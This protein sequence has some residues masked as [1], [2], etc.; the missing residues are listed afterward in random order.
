MKYPFVILFRYN[1][2]N[3][4]DDFV[5]KYKDALNCSISIINDPLQLNK[6]YD[7]NNQILM[8][9][10]KRGEYI[11][12]L[13]DFL[14]QRIINNKWLHFDNIYD[15][16]TMDETSINGFINIIDRMVNDLYIQN[17][18]GSRDSTR[19]VFS[20]FTTCYNSYHKIFRAYTSFLTQKFI[21]W[22]W[23]VLD[24]SPD[25]KHFEFL[26]ENFSNDKRVRLYKRSENSGSIGN[27]KN[28]VVM[29]CRGKYVLE[30]DHDDEIL[31]DT[32]KDA[33]DA[34]E[35]DKDVGFV[36][37]DFCNLYE[38]GK[39]H[40][41]GDFFGLGYAGYHC[42]KFRNKWVYVENTPNINNI[43]ISHLVSLPNHPRIW[44][45]DVLMKLGNYSEE[46][47]ICDDQ[48]ILLRT[49]METKCVKIS[50]LA[51]VQYMNEGDNNFSLIRN[52]EINRIGPHILTPLFY[53]KYGVHEKM[54]EIGAYEDEK[55]MDFGFLKEVWLRG[56]SYEHKYCN[57]I[58]NPDCN[59]QYCIIGFEYIVKNKEKIMELYNNPKNE[60]FLLDSR[61]S[62][63]YF[64]DWV[65][66]MGL[67]RMKFYSLPNTTQSELMRYFKFICKNCDDYEFLTLDMP[68]I[69]NNCDYYCRHDIV[70]MNSVETNNYLEIGVESGFTFQN[71]NIRNKTGV[72]PDPKFSHNNLKLL[73]SDDF[74]I[75]NKETFD[76]VFIDGMHQSEYVLNDF[77]NSISCLNDL[78]KIIIDDILPL[79]YN[80]QLRI[81]IKHYYENN[82][83]KYGEPWTGDVWKTIY[84]ILKN[85]SDK[86]DFKYYTHEYY[87]GVGVFYIKEKF[88]L[89]QL[90]VNEIQIYDYFTDYPIY[91]DLIKRLAQ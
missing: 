48:E 33:V 14:P 86:F 6:L 28:E 51:Y 61:Y 4:I 84:Y 90:A 71:V 79:S 41:Y 25:D 60:L 13:T 59:K 58:V 77:N 70:N 63:E 64:G 66:Y 27:V 12:D 36:Y 1:D 89:P 47:P 10:G 68:L 22:E 31:P 24:D 55:Y 50:K 76:I 9:Y 57:K 78:G 73:T 29:L 67:S 45:K 11:K 26:R 75:Q 37:M 18:C 43:T 5:E 44:R 88:Q 34:F 62:N 65:D 30:M 80:E 2:Y 54:K 56:E 17:V 19:P 81:P 87:R 7:S 3:N 53:K 52:W 39:N 8:T 83:L 40:K 32:L 20:I 69:V 72:D 21:D 42:V 46:L 15:F 38:N 82:I 16:T 91:Y 35:S 23:V 49:A 74:F 85:Y